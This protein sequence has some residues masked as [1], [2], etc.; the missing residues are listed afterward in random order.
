MTYD[1]INDVPTPPFSRGQTDHDT[2]APLPPGGPCSCATAIMADLANRSVHGKVQLWKGGPYW[3]DTNIG[4]EKPE[5]YGFY[6]W[7]G[8]TV[9]Y[10]REGDAWVAR[11][12][13]SSDFEFD[14]KHTPT[15]DKSLSTLTSE[16]WIIGGEERKSLLGKLFGARRDS[17]LTTKHDA[18]QVPCVEHG[19]RDASCAVAEKDKQRIHFSSLHPKS[20]W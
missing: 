12:G 5:D 9:G 11:D 15:C 4:A 1:T 10:K 17:V 13:S 14:E 19:P 18:A 3:A 20:L 8:D 7:W 16:G 2:H 6:F